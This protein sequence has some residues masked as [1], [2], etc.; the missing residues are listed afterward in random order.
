[1]STLEGTALS[2]IANAPIQTQKIYLYLRNM[3]LQCWLENPRKELTFRS[4]WDKL[5]P[6]YNSDQLLA[7]RV[8]VFLNR[9]GYINF[10]IFEP[11]GVSIKKEVKIS[12]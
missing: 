1:L 9:H 2:D 8:F 5:E 4:V 12:T 3:T 7:V 10:G 11:S 6:P